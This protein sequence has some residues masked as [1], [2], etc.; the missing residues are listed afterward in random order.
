ME[1]QE[2]LQLALKRR[3]SDIHLMVGAYP[4]LRIDGRLEPIANAPAP[5][6]EYIEKIVLQLC[7]PEQKDLLLTNKEIDFSFALGEMVRFRVNAFHQKG[8][9]AA[10][11]RLIPM[12]IPTL[13]ELHLPKVLSNF[14]KMRQGFILVTG[15]T[16]HGKS[17]SLAAMI[18]QIN[19]E[20][21]YHIITVED[22]IEYI[23]PSRKALIAQREM[24]QDTHSWERALRSALREDPDVVLVGEMRDYE[25]I[26][27]A[28]TIAET[29]H[30]VFATLHTNS[31]AQTVDRI[32]DVFPEHQQDQ[33]KLQFSNVF[34][35]IVS[36]RLLPAIDGGRYPCSEILLATPAVR[37]IIRE[38]KSHLIDNTI[39][40]STQVGMM[41]L[42]SSL[43]SLV[44]GGKVALDV[45]L[46]YSLKPD[47]LMRFVKGTAR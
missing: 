27:A 42:E 29:G 5:T 36:Q 6:V 31:A 16:G 18:N 4:T 24:H 32:V 33:V 43:A 25:T 23:F 9:L 35:G 46:S 22:P 12:K 40:T 38:G 20:R 37:N 3:A 2:I 28:L 41:T 10:S 17:T 34:E 39:Q 19:E 45:A 44:K 47:E 14:T 7:S 13:E 21:A 30:L 1:I 26:A 15:P 8:Y 11:L